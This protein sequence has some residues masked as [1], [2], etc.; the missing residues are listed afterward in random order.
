MRGVIVNGA[1]IQKVRLSCGLTQEQLA[2]N[3]D[4]DVKTVRKAEQGKRLDLGTLTRLARALGTELHR[5]R[6]ATPS[7]TELEI[8]R[9]DRVLQWH[10]AWESHDM[11]A[12]LDGYHHDAILSLPGGP[13]LKISGICIGKDAIR[14]MSE[15]A[16]SLCKSDQAHTVNLMLYVCDDTVIL[17]GKKIVP[18]SQGD[19]VRLSCVHIFTFR[20]TLIAGQQVEYDTL[21]FARLMQWNPNKTQE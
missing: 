5:L 3:A 15:L 18:V 20:G 13:S 2:K 10:R 17:K 4:V 12:L 21:E 8:I 11:V 14:Q 7:G 16:W 1:E 6:I 9:R 19:V